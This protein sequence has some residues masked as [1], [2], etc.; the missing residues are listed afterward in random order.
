[1]S[2]KCGDKGLFLKKHAKKTVRFILSVIRIF[3]FAILSFLMLESLGVLMGWK[4]FLSIK[5]WIVKLCPDLWPVLSRLARD[6]KGDL[7]PVKYLLEQGGLI[8]GALVAVNEI[9]SV[10]IYGISMKQVVDHYFPAFGRLFI[11]F[12]LYPAFLL[13]GGYACRKDQGFVA[14]LCL[15]GIICCMGYAA[16]M[17]FSLT[18]SERR[19]EN[20]VKK[21]VKRNMEMAEKGQNKFPQK[22][23]KYQNKSKKYQE[24]KLKKRQEKLKRQQEKLGGCV[25][26]LAVY[27]GQQWDKG[28]MGQAVRSDREIETVLIEATETWI[29]LTGSEETLPPNENR[30]EAKRITGE[31]EKPLRTVIANM[32]PDFFKRSG[33][34]RKTA[35]QVLYRDSVCPGYDGEIQKFQ[36]QVFLCGRIWEHLFKHAASEEIQG[37]MA[38]EILHTAMDR[39]ERIY[40]EMAFGLVLHL[41]MLL[42]SLSR[43]DS[44]D[45]LEKKLDFLLQVMRA[46]ADT[47]EGDHRKRLPLYKRREAFAERTFA[48]SWAEILY[49]VAA[50][51]Q[52]GVAIEQISGKAERYTVKIIEKIRALDFPKPYYSKM[53]RKRENYIVYAFLLFSW[54]NSEVFPYVSVRVLQDVERTIQSR[55]QLIKEKDAGEGFYGRKQL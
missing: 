14:V 17:A 35:R 41:N 3:L 16:H 39:G 31:K 48:G 49:V 15:F 23:E 21:Y 7:E 11:Q 6:Q 51:L 4:P 13:L 29:L 55:L 40:V 10:R 28:N 34:E 33:E 50:M 38:C 37:R 2:E 46:D 42:P 54:E 8:S 20:L 18:L 32:F 45:M 27:I 19:R 9:R 53:Q 24:K 22:A 25:Q 30:L 47:V 43:D 5:G 1:M 44:L 36:R 12:L 26:E 52:W